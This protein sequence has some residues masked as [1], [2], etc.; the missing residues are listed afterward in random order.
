MVC[1]CARSIPAKPFQFL[2]PPKPKR[3]PSSHVRSREEQKHI[4][5]LLREGLR[6]WKQAG[7]VCCHS[8]ETRRKMSE[9]RRWAAYVRGV[10]A[11]ISQR[12]QEQPK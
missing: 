10:Q 8:P 12:V 5:T 6:R 7:G 1:L 2:V 9:G 3:R 4:V 11:Q